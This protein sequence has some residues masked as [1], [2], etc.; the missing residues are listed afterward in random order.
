V[1]HLAI[2]LLSSA[3][4]PG[5]CSSSSGLKAGSNASPKYIS[6]VIPSGAIACT[7][8]SAAV[9]PDP[10][11]VLPEMSRIRTSA[12]IRTTY[13][14]PGR[15][16]EQPETSHFL[17]INLNN[18]APNELGATPGINGTVVGGQIMP[19]YRTGQVFCP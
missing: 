16:P 12:V 2:R 5:G 14:A 6:A 17:N 4:G 8:R 9:L 1:C 18:I 13:L 15:S 11:L 3:A 7:V 10:R 19:A